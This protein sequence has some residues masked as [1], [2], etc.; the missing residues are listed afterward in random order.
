MQ[1][2]RVVNHIL[3]LLVFL[4][5]LGGCTTGEAGQNFKEF[6]KKAGEV[7]KKIKD[8]DLKTA[9]STYSNE[10]QDQDQSRQG[11]SEEI[12]TSKD[13]T[14]QQ[15]K[16]I[17]NWLQE[18]DYNRYGDARNAIYSGGT[19]LFDEEAGEAMGRYE[20]ILKKFPNILQRIKQ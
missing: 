8:I 17:D 2:I 15:K 6:D 14:E 4:L 1:K 11:E 20:Y 7:L 16:D 18:N 10:S 13:L 19:P 9:S 12:K 3:L 5:L